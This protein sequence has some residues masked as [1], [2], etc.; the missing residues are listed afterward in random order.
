MSLK[1]IAKTNAARLLDGLG[2]SYE[3]HE[4]T[5][6]ENDLSATAAAAALGAPP[7]QVFKT[8]AA[9]GDK[10]GVLM[11][12]IP[13]EA[14]LNFK[15]LAAVANNKHVELVPLRDVQPLTGY[16]RGGCSPLCLKKPYPVWIDETALLFD[17]I[18]VSAGR[19]G[20]Q[21]FIGPEDL[22][23][24]AEA[25][26]ADIADPPAGCGAEPRKKKTR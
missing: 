11:A 14:E 26:F 9:R 25:D 13:A 8:L 10:T 17:R 21:L 12:C 23:R 4:F 2:I 1:K 16:V 24:A 19:R 20:V 3:L 7:E 18:Y 15:R 22:A 6:D 5:P